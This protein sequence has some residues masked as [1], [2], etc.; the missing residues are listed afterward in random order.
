MNKENC[1]LK[2]VD[3][4]KQYKSLINLAKVMYIK[5]YFSTEIKKREPKIQ[6]PMFNYYL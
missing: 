5:T 4:I 3:E 2:L 1:A 6:K